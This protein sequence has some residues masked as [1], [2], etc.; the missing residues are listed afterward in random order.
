MTWSLI[1]VVV[2]V[3]AVLVGVS[4]RQRRH[5]GGATLDEARRDAL[6]RDPGHG[7]GFTG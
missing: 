2:V 6:R 3:A 7:G 1:L 4:L 5:A